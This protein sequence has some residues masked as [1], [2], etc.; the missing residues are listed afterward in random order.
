MNLV[1][2][3][4]VIPLK[5]IPKDDLE[6]FL[7]SHIKG[8][9]EELNKTCSVNRQLGSYIAI[10]NTSSLQESEEVVKKISTSSFKSLDN[11]IKNEYGEDPKTYL[12]TFVLFQASTS[13]NKIIITF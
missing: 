3:K 10:V 13:E 11:F 7:L 2:D 5:I 12:R 9:C 8:K 4:N 1:I 6:R